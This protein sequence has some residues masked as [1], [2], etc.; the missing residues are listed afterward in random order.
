VAD[1]ESLDS[2]RCFFAALFLARDQKVELEQKDDDILITLV[3]N[4]P[5]KEGKHVKN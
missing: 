2:I 1:L 3:N 5:K 4:E